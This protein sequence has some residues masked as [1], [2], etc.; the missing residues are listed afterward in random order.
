MT[1]AKYIIELQRLIVEQQ[2]IQ[3]V[4]P[5]NSE[6]W[7]NASEELARLGELLNVAIRHSGKNVRGANAR[8]RAGNR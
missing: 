6:N 8:V 7:Q 5:P 2:N 1:E 4:C 3:K